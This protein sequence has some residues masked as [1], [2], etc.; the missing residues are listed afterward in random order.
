[1]T[2][3]DGESLG[4]QTYLLRPTAVRIFVRQNKYEAGR[5][6]IMVFNWHLDDSVGVDVS[7]LGLQIGDQYEVRDAQNYFESPVAKGTYEGKSIRLPLN[8]KQVTSP[9][10]NVERIPNHTAPQFAAFV[11]Q[12]S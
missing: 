11:I 3:L 8:L 5:G 1:M 10:G 2:G 6:H 12:K 9:I 4:I 7:S